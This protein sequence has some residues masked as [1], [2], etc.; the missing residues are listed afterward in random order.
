MAKINFEMDTVDKTYTL[1]IDGKP[2]ENVCSISAYMD[3]PYDN[4]GD[5]DED[6]KCCITINTHV[7][8]ED[9]GMRTCTSISAAEQEELKKQDVT[10]KTAE[11]PVIQHIADFILNNRKR[12]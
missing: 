12:K 1:T 11:K 9:E 4:D 7:R 5:G 10:I 6:D 3:Y 8:D 2:V